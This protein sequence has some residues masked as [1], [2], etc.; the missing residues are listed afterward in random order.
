M[1]KALIFVVLQLVV[2]A[3]CLGYNESGNQENTKRVY[4][5]PT[6]EKTDSSFKGVYRISW[7][8]LVGVNIYPNLTNKNL[9]YAVNDVR[10][11]K[12]KLI[13]YCQI[14]ET[15]FLLFSAGLE[16][17][18][19]LDN[20]IIFESLRQRFDGKMNALS[21]DASV[22]IE[23]K[24][25]RWQIIDVYNVYNVNK[26]GNELRFYHS[27]IK[28]L[29]DKQAS[30]Q[31]IRDAMGQLTDPKKVK[32]ND[33]ILIYFSGHGQTVELSTGGEM[34]FILPYDAEVDLADVKNLAPY[35]A[36]CLGMDELKHF[37][38]M[39]PAKHVLYLVDACYSGLAVSSTKGLQPEIP[40]YLEKVAKLRV[41]QVITAGSRNEQTIE[42]SEWGHGAF[43][44]KL[45]EALRTGVADNDGD[46]VTTGRELAGHLRKVV[47]KI[48][49][50]TPQT[51]QFGYFEGEGE[52]LFLQDGTIPPTPED[53]KNGEIPMPPIAEDVDEEG[54]EPPTPGPTPTPALKE[55]P[56][57][58]YIA[59]S[60]VPAEDTV[61]VEWHGDQAGRGEAIQE[62]E[63]VFRIPEDSQQIR[64]IWHRGNEEMVSGWLY[65]PEIKQRA[66][67]AREK[68]VSVPE[69][70]QIR[71]VE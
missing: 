9:S 56:R 65:P 57:F 25:S 27:N 31:A 45:L 36:T 4:S 30:W 3:M 50:P 40:D 52:F 41:R 2:I 55:Y 62:Q 53:D 5:P 22:V 43:T 60:G 21:D 37:S 35:Y 26:E 7:A 32:Y 8:L 12:K 10:E 71:M 20:G 51:P 1:R 61:T 66:E 13:E 38:T 47:P 23:E 33:R 58:L 28:T 67:D 6:G 44:Y 24:G 70:F 54:Q 19:D 14:D 17:Q 29:T 69:I 63:N 48:T 11:M 49:S 46:G 15:W 64:L 34:G 59:V 39:I 68:P 16:F 18:S 42:K